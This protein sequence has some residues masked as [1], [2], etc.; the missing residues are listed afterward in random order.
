MTKA[1][2]LSWPPA[3]PNEANFDFG[4]RLCYQPLCERRE[5]T[6]NGSAQ[7]MAAQALPCILGIGEAP[8]AADIIRNDTSEWKSHY[9][10]AYM[11]MVTPRFFPI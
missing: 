10:F 7:T 6:D 8:L 3:Q 2:R 11:A 5:C 9:E 1:E 4:S